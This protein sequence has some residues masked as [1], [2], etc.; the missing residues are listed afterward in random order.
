MHVSRIVAAGVCAVLVVVTAVAAVVGFSYDAR[1]RDVAR[2]DVRRAALSSLTGEL[3][4]LVSSTR[5]VAAL[6][7]ASEDVTDVE[8][9][10][11]VSPLLRD[12][13]AS[14][15]AWLAHVPGA[16]CA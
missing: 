15:Y 5:E 6:F 1:Q 2:K 8:F 11:F 10:Q 7:G 3:D 16:R 13:S 14:A 9:R 12:G 4:T